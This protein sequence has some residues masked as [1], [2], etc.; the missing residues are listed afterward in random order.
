MKPEANSAC[1]SAHPHPSSRFS[2][3]SNNTSRP[4]NCKL[5]ISC[6]EWRSFKFGATHPVPHSIRYNPAAI[7]SNAVT[8]DE[9]TRAPQPF[10]APASP[11]YY[12]S[13]P[14]PA[15]RTFEGTT[16]RFGKRSSLRDFPSTYVQRSSPSRHSVRNWYSSLDNHTML[17]SHR[18]IRPETSR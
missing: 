14:V 16:A 6:A 7:I 5:R 1:S 15:Q 9:L 18:A 11:P 8:V 10:Y 17:S 4:V 2:S 13:V 3:A 12:T